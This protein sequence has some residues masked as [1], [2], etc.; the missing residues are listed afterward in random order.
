[1]VGNWDKSQYGRALKTKYQAHPDIHIL[2]PIYNQQ[3]LDVL[4][5]NSSLYVHG[6]SAGG[7]NPSLVE[8]M[9]LGLPILAN[10][11]SYNRVT[12][13]NKALFFNDLE[14]L[15]D[16][17]SNIYTTRLKSI[18][19]EMEKI[20]RRRYTWSNIVFRYELLIEEALQIND[21]ME[22]EACTHRLPYRQL[23]ASG[24]AHLKINHNY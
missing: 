24:H 8:A 13:E 12:T 3:Q 19:I 20:A 7:T 15:T 11:V 16:E 10:G 18:G 9:N 23:L 5:S 6:H 17:I 1:M 2:D 14:S 22:V 21:K 4:R